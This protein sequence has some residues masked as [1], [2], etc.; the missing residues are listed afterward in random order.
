MVTGRTHQIRVH[1]SHLNHP[2]LGDSIY[3]M[4]GDSCPLALQSYDFKFKHPFVY[5]VI[6][7]KMEMSNTLKELLYE[8]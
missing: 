3:G 1:F 7:V 2:L 4:E 5:I 6:D 8:K